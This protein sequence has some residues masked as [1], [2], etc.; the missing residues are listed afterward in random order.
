[1]TGPQL[2]I[3]PEF[4]QPSLYDQAEA[5]IA[6][7]WLFMVQDAMMFGGLFLA[8]IYSRYFNQPGFD[9][10]S[11]HTELWLGT[12][13]T[14]VLLTGSLCY[15]CGLAFIRAGRNNL[16]MIALLCAAFLG[17]CY[18]GLEGYEWHLDFVA[19]T[20]VND[21]NFPV[22][23]E[24]EGGAKLFYTFY[25]IIT[26]LHA[27]H[28]AIALPL[29]AYILRR[30]WR[31]DFSATYYTPVEVVGIYWNFITVLWMVLWPFIYLIG[32]MP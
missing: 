26:V 5:A 6:G 31:R 25:W 8:W 3:E 30:A 23:G 32:R 27:A 28:M 17:A 13:I 4:S 18:L 9:A 11:R 1:M 24:L 2:T 16:M 15:G 22:H 29:M 7:I 20:W 12:V 19:H 10:G 21:P 14:G